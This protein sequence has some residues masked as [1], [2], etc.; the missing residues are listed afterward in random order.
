[1]AS[2]LFILTA[3]TILAITV[4]PGL[5]FPKDVEVTDVSGMTVEK[6]EDTL[7]KVWVYRRFGVNRDR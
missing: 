1:M 6:A 5:L 3:A 7:K 2:I 4:F